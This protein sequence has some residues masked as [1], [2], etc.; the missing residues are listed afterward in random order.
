MYF[1]KK[2][3]NALV[4]SNEEYLDKLSEKIKNRDEKIKSL[5]NMS[6]NKKVIIQ[7]EIIKEDTTTIENLEEKLT[8][9]NY[10][11]KNRFIPKHSINAFA[12]AGLGF[13]V[14]SQYFKTPQ[15][16][17]YIGLMYKRHLWEGRA[18]IGGGLA[19]KVYKEVGIGAI[20]EVGIKF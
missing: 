14:E 10:K 7:K 8:K 6:I 19:V 18:H 4:Q 9:T 3:T 17:I 11:L 13:D 20:V 16:D 5:E 12:L 1:H 15:P 2:S